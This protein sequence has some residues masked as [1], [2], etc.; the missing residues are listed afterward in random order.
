MNRSI[1]HSKAAAS[2]TELVLE[3]FRFNGRLLAAGDRLGEG[4]D[5]TSARWQILGAVEAGPLSVAGIGRRM[6]LT[7]Q[8]V[9]RVADE[10]ARSGIVEYRPNPDHKRAKLVAMTAKGL[11]AYAAITAR[12]IAWSNKLVDRFSAARIRAATAVVRA[13]RER[14]E[15]EE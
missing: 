11:A 1:K 2:A 5:L 13:L 6:G 10:L 14:L 4:L 9:Q 12:Q 3:T 8:A 7:R 15:R